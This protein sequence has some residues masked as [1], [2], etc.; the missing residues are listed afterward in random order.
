MMNGVA[1]QE[2]AE[3]QKTEKKLTPALEEKK[4]MNGAV[5]GSNGKTTLSEQ[6]RNFPP[7]ENK[8]VSDMLENWL[9]A[10]LPG[11]LAIEMTVKKLSDAVKLVEESTLELNSKFKSLAETAKKQS[12]TITSVVEKSESLDLNGKKVSMAEFSDITTNVLQE[13]VSK[14]IFISKLSINMVYSLDDALKSMK[15]IEAFN[16]KIQA[17]NKQ[18]HLLSLNATIESARAGELGKGFA[19]VADEVR[20]VS[21]EINN[22]SDEMNQKISLVSKSV[23]EGYDKLHGVATTDITDTIKTQELLENLMKVLMKQTDDFKEILGSSAQD[24]EE[25]SRTISGMIVGMQFQD[26]TAQYIQNSMGAIQEVKYALDYLYSQSSG[27][28]ENKNSRTEIGKMLIDNIM[29]H[30][31]LSEFKK[32]YLNLLEK[33]GV[34]EG[35]ASDIDDIKEESI[36]L[37]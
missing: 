16:T 29:S 2:T 18:T 14:I 25:S 10:A 6:K 33:E 23:K 34:R 28:L 9:G 5:N 4:S 19:V 8:D 13:T 21:K 22:L 3:T 36:E 11:S 17:I 32:E 12:K 24:S 27:L 26:R 1:V 7:I 37:F 20:N 35:G 15:E 30:L 31:Q